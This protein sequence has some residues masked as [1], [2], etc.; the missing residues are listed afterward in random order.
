MYEGSS[1][2]YHIV[3]TKVDDNLRLSIHLLEYS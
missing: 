2:E 3:S 1:Y